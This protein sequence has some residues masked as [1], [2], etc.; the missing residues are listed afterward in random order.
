MI[1]KNKYKYTSA[2]KNYEDY[3]S[4]RVLYGVRGATNFPVRLGSEIFQHCTAYLKGKGKQ[5]PYRIYDPFCGVAYSLT[6][7]G[8]LHGKEIESIAASDIDGRILEFADKNLS[9]LSS[10]GLEKRIEELKIFIEKYQKEAHK[11][12]LKSAYRLRE[13]VLNSIK[14]QCF[15]ES[16]LD[17]E[18]IPKVIPAL[19]IVITDLPYGRLTA[20]NGNINS[21]HPVE[22]FLGKLNRGMSPISIAAIVCDK[23]QSIPWQGDKSV[24]V[25]GKRKVY[26]LKIDRATSGSRDASVKQE[27]SNLFDDKKFHKEK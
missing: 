24:M 2:E 5:G 6:T 25:F 8:F 17:F 16:A 13:N 9:L 22:D 1:V 26:L 7:L 21:S 10:E 15:Q 19:D 20:W 23:H 3:A 11:E 18:E 27:L 4:G 12:A 14:I